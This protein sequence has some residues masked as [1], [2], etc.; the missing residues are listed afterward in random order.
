MLA[1]GQSAQSFLR[2]IIYIIIEIFLGYFLNI[3]FTSSFRFL[4]INALTFV[5]TEKAFSRRIIPAVSF[6]RH[7]LF[8]T[9][10]LQ[11]RSIFFVWILNALVAMNGCALEVYLLRKFFD[12][13]NSNQGDGSCGFIVHRPIVFNNSSFLLYLLCQQNFITKNTKTPLPCT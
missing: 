6:A 4:Q 2:T 5:H 10:F 3:K 7:T 11:Q 8:H 13:I 12:W 9:E 1:W